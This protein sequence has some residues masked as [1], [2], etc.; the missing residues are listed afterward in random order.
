MPSNSIMDKYDEDHP[1][2]CKEF[3]HC[4]LTILW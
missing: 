2:S 3:R 1:E 4:K